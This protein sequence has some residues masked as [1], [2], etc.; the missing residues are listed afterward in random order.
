LLIVVCKNNAF[1]LHWQN[2]PIAIAIAIP[3]VVVVDDFS[4]NVDV[5]IADLINFLGLILV[6]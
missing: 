5:A 6:I 2:P 3:S 1:E 4:T